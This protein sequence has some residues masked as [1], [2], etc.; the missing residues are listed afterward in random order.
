[1]TKAYGSGKLRVVVWGDGLAGVCRST[2]G[3]REKGSI[4]LIHT[5]NIPGVW[6]SM[7]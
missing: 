5:G 3:Y 7:C 6:A 2:L 4:L 1:M